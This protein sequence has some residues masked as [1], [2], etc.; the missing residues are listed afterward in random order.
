MKSR[1]LRV[2]SI[3]IPEGRGQQA[4]ATQCDVRVASRRHLL[5]RLNRILAPLRRWSRHL[6]YLIGSLRPRAVDAFGFQSVPEPF[7]VTATVSEQLL[8][9]QAGSNGPANSQ[10]R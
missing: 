3:Q 2:S 1:R 4:T 10:S 7:G 9:D 5:R 8:S 6:L